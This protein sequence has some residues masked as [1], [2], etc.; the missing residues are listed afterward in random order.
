MISTL[1]ALTYFSVV[2][3]EARSCVLLIPP[4]VDCASD[5]QYQILAVRL[6]LPHETDVHFAPTAI[7]GRL[8]LPNFPLH[9]TM[10]SSCEFYIQL[11]A[12]VTGKS[13]R[14]AGGVCAQ[15]PLG[16]RLTPPWGNPP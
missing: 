13:L 3:L 14:Q 1:R 9:V 4:L 7:F 12:G 6:L 5:S 8:Y 11:F 15:Y 16:S 2:Q 10:C